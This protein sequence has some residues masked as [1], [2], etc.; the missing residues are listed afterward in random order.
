MKTQKMTFKKLSREEMKTIKAGSIGT[1][2]CV[3]N[4][5]CTYKCSKDGVCSA[6]CVAAETLS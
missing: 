6:C 4:D 1:G 5:N 3:T 2:D